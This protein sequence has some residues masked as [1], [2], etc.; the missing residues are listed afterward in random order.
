[1]HELTLPRNSLFPLHCSCLNNLSLQ[2][3]CV[4][5]LYTGI[6]IVCIAKGNDKRNTIMDDILIVF[7]CYK[8]ICELIMQLSNITV[9]RC[10]GSCSLPEI[11]TFELS[12]MD[13]KHHESDVGKAV[14]SDVWK[15]R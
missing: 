9:Q 8:Y 15:T 3:I 10:S 13:C 2:I 5:T 12:R 6:L 4:V 7:I 1:M 14:L 11:I